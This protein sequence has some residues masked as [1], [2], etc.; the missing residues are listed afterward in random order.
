MSILIVYLSGMS[1]GIGLTGIAVTMYLLRNTKKKQEGDVYVI[2]ITYITTFSCNNVSMG[3]SRIY[4]R[5]L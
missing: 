2:S 5:T 3:H 1:M 4:N